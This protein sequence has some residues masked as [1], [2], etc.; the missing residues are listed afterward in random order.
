MLNEESVKQQATSNKQGVNNN[1][2]Y[3]FLLLCIS[4]IFYDSINYYSIN[5]FRHPKY[6][7]ELEKIRKQ[8]ESSS[9]K[10][11]GTSCP[12]DKI[13]DPQASIDK[14]RTQIHKRQASSRKRQAP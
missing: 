7:K 2:K 5:M 13:Q 12:D 3:K 9:N 14:H 6:Y 1:D 8:N 4:I 11:K 10:L